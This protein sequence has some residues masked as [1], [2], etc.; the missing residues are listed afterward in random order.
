MGVR[1][2]GRELALQALYSM[3]MNQLDMRATLQSFRENVR[4]TGLVRSFAEELVAGVIDKREEIDRLI[5][6][7]SKNWA[8]SRMGKVDLNIL[9]LA[10]YEL[11]Y[12]SDI[13]KNVT[14]N[15][16]IEVAKKFGTEESPAFVNG[17][18]DEISSGIT[19]KS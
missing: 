16:A 10:A 4:A 19:E 17:I 9:R 8:I 14:I 6:E 13:P 1:R 11:C 18:L 2:E 3:D 15:E 5:E 7:K 12:R